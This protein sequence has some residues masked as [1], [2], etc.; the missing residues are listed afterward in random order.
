MFSLFFWVVNFVTMCFSH[1][2][3][4]LLLLSS[5]LSSRGFT[6]LLSI[7]FSH[8]LTSS[9]SCQF[10]FSHGFSV[11]F[12]AS[13][14]V[15]LLV[16]LSSCCQFCSLMMLS[17][18]VLSIFFS[19]GIGC[20]IL[21]KFCFSLWKLW[22]HWGFLCFQ[23]VSTLV[24]HVVCNRSIPVC[25]WLS[26]KNSRA[27][28]KSELL[29]C[30]VCKCPK[31]TTAAER[32]NEKEWNWC[33]SNPWDLWDGRQI[34]TAAMQTNLWTPQ[35]LHC[36]P[37]ITVLHTILAACIAA[38]FPSPLSTQCASLLSNSLSNCGHS[39]QP[40]HMQQT[41]LSKKLDWIGKH[42]LTHKLSA[43]STI[44]DG[45]WSHKTL[46][47]T[48]TCSSQASEIWCQTLFDFFGSCDVGRRP[49]AKPQ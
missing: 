41:L 40:P 39:I 2:F 36:S 4:V 15:F 31:M 6:P 30:R 42:T 33:K 25:C 21:V 13:N 20:I 47:P 23:P 22:K 49:D 35:C 18:L 28:K 29:L 44:D 24:L 3:I 12:L 48:H 16:W 38:L 17:V 46:N 26:Y 8:G 37:P 19:H 9:S 7:F 14:F 43:A 5:I 11:F 32:Q 1:G 34:S 45:A 10:Y 27:L